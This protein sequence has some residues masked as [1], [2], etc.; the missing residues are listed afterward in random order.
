MFG[1]GSQMTLAFK[2]DRPGY[3]EGSGYSPKV[4]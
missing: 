3:V 1:T 2:P 4:D